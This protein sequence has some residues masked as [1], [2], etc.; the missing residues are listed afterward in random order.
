MFIFLKVHSMLFRMVEIIF[1]SENYWPSYMSLD[2]MVRDTALLRLLSENFP[3]EP[4][5]AAS[6]LFSVA[7]YFKFSHQCKLFVKTRLHALAVHTRFIWFSPN[8]GWVQ[9]L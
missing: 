4:R 3:K 6:S 9:I 5:I 2:M 7:R 8:R 1:K